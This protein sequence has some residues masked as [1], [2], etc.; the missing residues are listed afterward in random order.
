[1]PGIL[2]PVG[3]RGFHQ[4]VLYREQDRYRLLG[5]GVGALLESDAGAEREQ[6]LGLFLLN[7]L[8]LGFVHIRHTYRV[9]EADDLFDRKHIQ[10]GG[11]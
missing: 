10:A 8:F 6:F 1:M 3:R 5:A 9:T 11:Q 4:V 2:C 7:S